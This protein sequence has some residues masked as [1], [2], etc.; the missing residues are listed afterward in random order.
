MR[1]AP[2]ISGSNIEVL[3]HYESKNGRTLR[4]VEV[5]IVFIDFFGQRLFACSTEFKNKCFQ[6]VPSPGKIICHI[7]KLPLLPGEYRILLWSSV[8]GQQADRIEHAGVCRVLE[9]DFFGSGKLPQL[10]KHGPFLVP[11]EWRIDDA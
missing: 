6:T 10:N 1:N 7:Q 5:A 4:K 9:G 11:H 2:I 8:D 3:L